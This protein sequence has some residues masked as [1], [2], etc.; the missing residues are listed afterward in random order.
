MHNFRDRS[1]PSPLILSAGKVP[2]ITRVYHVDPWSIEDYK[3]QYLRARS[4]L[5]PDR[6]PA[7]LLRSVVM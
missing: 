5:I 2:D 1:R 4:V 6:V 3:P 7:V